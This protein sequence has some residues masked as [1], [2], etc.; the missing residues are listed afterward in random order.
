MVGHSARLL[1]DIPPPTRGHAIVIIIRSNV[2]WKASYLLCKY[3]Q[4]CNHLLA[5]ID[6]DT[7]ISAFWY[8]EL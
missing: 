1:V 5:L 7:Y 4:P 3:G 6:H 8:K 2:L